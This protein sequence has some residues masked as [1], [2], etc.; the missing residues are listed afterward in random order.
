MKK[1]IISL[2]F[3]LG[4]CFS[5][6]LFYGC[7]DDKGNY[8]YEEKQIITIE[9]I[10]Q[11]INVLAH[12]E[13]LSLTPTIISN[14]EGELNE[15]NGHFEFLYQY[16]KDDKWYDMDTHKDLY[17]R[18]DLPEGTFSCRFV[19][20]DKRTGIKTFRP[21][22]LKT[23]A[24]TSEGWLLLCN[25]GAEERVRMD[26]LSQIS[27]ERIVPIYDVVQL[28]DGVPP[29]HHAVNIGVFFAPLGGVP[30]Q[31]A[32]MSE[33]GTYLL[34]NP[35]GAIGIINGLAYELK[36]ALFLAYTNDHI[37]N[38]TCIPGGLGSWGRHDA[39]IAVSREGNA[40]TWNTGYQNGMFES[41]INTSV[42]GAPVEYKVAPFIGSNLSRA[43]NGYGVALLF[44]TDNHRFIGWDADGLGFGQDDPNG[45]KQRCYPLI[46]P[47]ANTKFS[48]NTGNMNLVCMLNTATTD[49]KVS[50]IMQDGVKR[51]I[52]DI[53]VITKDFNQMGAYL[54]V[55]APDFDKATLF[56][57]SSTRS[58][59][60]YAYQN[61]VYAY[62]YVLKQAK[63]ILTFG[64]NEEVTCID[65]IKYDNPQG[66]D[67]GF[68]ANMDDVTK[69]IYMSQDKELIVGTYDNNASDN[70]GGTLHFYQPS[71]EGL[72]VT[73]KKDMTKDQE[74]NELERVW[75]FSGYA[76]I[77]DVKYKETR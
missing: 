62:N 41:A 59:I 4:Y 45:I 61:K 24:E 34:P 54:D 56:A 18:A 58:I 63:E 27:L 14:K 43:Q 72:D 6:S 71:M 3:V 32:M 36:T 9:G 25:E 47:D 21:F 19:V 12:S 55:Q 22:Y 7:S 10:P 50:C 69:G 17:W 48:F 26:M 8:D 49:A 13:Y 39:V 75:E 31:V 68:F 5:L 53:S 28:T 1:V 30:C 44:D 40:Y 70:N 60:Y 23:T 46:D 64:T 57:A 73:L 11:N 66:Y 77:V 67:G 65:F 38:W 51:H 2:S 42:P 52:Y 33:E 76:R 20:T 35:G 16:K 37:V 74:G 29:L 15:N